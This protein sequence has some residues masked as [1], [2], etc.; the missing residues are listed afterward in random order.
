MTQIKTPKL[1]SINHKTLIILTAALVISACSDDPKALI[2]ELEKMITEKKD[3]L[4]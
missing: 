1:I 2:G 3:N 4:S